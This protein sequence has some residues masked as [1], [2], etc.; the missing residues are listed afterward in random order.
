MSSTWFH[1]ISWNIF[2]TSC[3]S[4]FWLIIYLFY[5]SV[6][7]RSDEFS[8]SFISPH[9]PLW[10]KTPSHCC[11][12]TSRKRAEP[13]RCLK[14]TF[15]EFNFS[16]RSPT[17]PPPSE[18]AV[19]LFRRHA[20]PEWKTPHS[21]ACYESTRLLPYSLS[22]KRFT[23]GGAFF[24]STLFGRMLTHELRDEMWLF[25]EMSEGFFFVRAYLSLHYIK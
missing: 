13:D 22:Y 21:S 15:S 24:S 4:S 25:A 19:G 5:M 1:T 8:K 12:C 11:R 17:P 7:M 23:F 2:F 9:H 3:V 16:F 18:I 10:L 14:L 20:Y 6:N